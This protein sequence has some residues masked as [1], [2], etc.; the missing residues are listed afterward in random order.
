M[1]PRK[2]VFLRKT[3]VVTYSFCKLIYKN[4]LYQC[5][6]VKDLQIDKKI[7][8]SHNQW[9]ANWGIGPLNFE[10][11]KNEYFQWFFEWNIQHENYQAQTL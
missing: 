7:Y 8:D 5:H 9:K 11:F 6:H 4:D 3:V 10:Y 2:L 1:S